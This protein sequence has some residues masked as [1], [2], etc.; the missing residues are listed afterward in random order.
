MV[1]V[2]KVG[3]FRDVASVAASDVW[4]WGCLSV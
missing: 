3:M 4:Y 1:A 2:G